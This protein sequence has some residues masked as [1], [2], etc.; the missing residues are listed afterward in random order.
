MTEIPLPSDSDSRAM[1][2]AYELLRDRYPDINER[3]SREIFYQGFFQGL[4]HLRQGRKCAC[5]R[6]CDCE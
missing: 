5:A 1:H 4:E 6:D 2:E 3:S